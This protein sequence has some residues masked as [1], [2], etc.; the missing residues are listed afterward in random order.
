LTAREQAARL[1]AISDDLQSSV[2]MQAA[3]EDASTSRDLAAIQF[4]ASIDEGHSQL[5]RVAA[6]GGASVLA[7]QLQNQSQRSAAGQSA[8]SDAAVADAKIGEAFAIGF[9]EAQTEMIHQ[10][11]VNHQQAIQTGGSLAAMAM[12]APP[13]G[14]SGSVPNTKAPSSGQSR[15]P[16]VRKPTPAAIPT[17]P[18]TPAGPSGEKCLAYATGGAV[19]GYAAGPWGAALGGLGA[20]I[21][22]DDCR[23]L[24]KEALTR[25]KMTPE[26]RRQLEIWEQTGLPLVAPPYGPPGT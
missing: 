14:M 5:Q 4:A 21:A 11:G 2:S 12:G 7:A 1:A 19:A 25:N 6:E 16:A 23:A 9:G 3:R 15:T 13:T 24:A 10:V 22:S 26:L 20:A 8:F 17:V 18:A